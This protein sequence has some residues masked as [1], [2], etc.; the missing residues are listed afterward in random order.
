ML[1]PPDQEEHQTAANALPKSVAL[2]SILLGEAVAE[3]DFM[4]Y[5]N[6]K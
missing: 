4:R 2:F 5:P 1:Q 6:M 3:E